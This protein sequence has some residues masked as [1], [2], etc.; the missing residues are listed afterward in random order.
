MT[1]ET[2]YCLQC[3]EKHILSETV[4]TKKD[5]TAKVGDKSIVVPAVLGHHCPT[6]GECEFSEGEGKRFSEVVEKLR[7]AKE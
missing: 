6:C 2:R 4:F 7:A 1:E 5:L 3:D